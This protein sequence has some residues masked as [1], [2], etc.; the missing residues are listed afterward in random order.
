MGFGHTH[1]LIISTVI[2]IVFSDMQNL[3]LLDNI[4]KIEFSVFGKNPCQ[5]CMVELQVK[6]LELVLKKTLGQD[7]VCQSVNWPNNFAFSLASTVTNFVF[8][9]AVA[10]FGIWYTNKVNRKFKI[11]ERSQ[12]N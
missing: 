2:C 3:E 4:N 7:L 9:V 12:R 5:N 8:N 6:Y 11:W 10:L 1:L